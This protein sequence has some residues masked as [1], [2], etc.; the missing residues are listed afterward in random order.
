ML[1]ITTFSTACY[2]PTSTKKYMCNKP[3]NLVWHEKHLTALTVARPTATD[4]TELA[5]G[6]ARYKIQKLTFTTPAAG[7]ASYNLIATWVAMD[8]CLDVIEVHL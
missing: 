1:I 5:Y 3:K 7:N 2:I 4:T 8:M 6:T